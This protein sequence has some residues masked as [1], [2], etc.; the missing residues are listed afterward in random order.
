[1]SS[2]RTARSQ[3]PRFIPLL[4]DKMRDLARNIVLDKADYDDIRATT[5]DRL[6]PIW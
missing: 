2:V 3:H 4:S 5:S 1:M 6:E